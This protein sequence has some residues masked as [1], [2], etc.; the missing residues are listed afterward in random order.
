VKKENRK[1]N[2]CSRQ[3]PPVYYSSSFPFSLISLCSHANSKPN[4]SLTSRPDNP[5]HPNGSFRHSEEAGSL[6][7]QVPDPESRGAPSPLR[8]AV[9]LFHYRRRTFHYSLQPNKLIK[10]LVLIELNWV[11]YLFTGRGL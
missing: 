3:L 7:I 6:G 5:P 9:R 1:S 4:Y 8:R 10:Y 2:P 11:V